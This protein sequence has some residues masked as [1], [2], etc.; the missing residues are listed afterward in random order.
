MDAG[1]ILGI[2]LAALFILLTAIRAY[3]RDYKR[4]MRFKAPAEYA[5][6][7]I[8]DTM[9]AQSFGKKDL[10][11]RIISGSGEATEG[12]K[13]QTDP[14]EIYHAKACLLLML[15]TNV[16]KTEGLREVSLVEINNLSSQ[17]EEIK[18]GL[19]GIE[20]K[21]DLR[22]S[23]VRMSYAFSR[24]DW[25]IKSYPRLRYDA[26]MSALRSEI[27]RMNHAIN[28]LSEG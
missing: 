4:Y 21:Y 5:G 16:K 15:L 23:D 2:G 7:G 17:M 22:E 20:T 28:N 10:K 25:L 6:T 12:E 14:R 26:D 9:S 11:D 1:F 18:K 24:I 13:E 3:K 8:T 19:E 27:R